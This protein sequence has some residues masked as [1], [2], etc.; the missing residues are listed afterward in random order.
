YARVPRIK[1][2]VDERVFSI[3][4]TVNPDGRDHFLKGT[5]A[6]SRTGHVPVDDDNDGVADEDGDDDL[7]GN[8]VIE[9]IRK[10]APGQGTLPKNAQDPR[11][12]EPAPGAQPGAYV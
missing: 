9:Q 2:L 6:G 5:G 1:T 12:L 3:V 4:P 11:I 8:G 7:N 10:H